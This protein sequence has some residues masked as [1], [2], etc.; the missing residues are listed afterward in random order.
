TFQTAMDHQSVEQALQIVPA[1]QVTYQWKGNTL[2]VQPVAGQLAPNTQYRLTLGSTAT[3]SAGTQLGKPATIVFVT[4]P[5]PAPALPTPTPTPVATGVALGRLVD[6]TPAVTVTP[7][8]SPDSATLYYAD[9]NRAL[10]S[11]PAGGGAPV[12]LGVEGVRSIAVKADG[13]SLAVQSDGGLID[14]LK[15]DGGALHTYV[16]PDA[17]ALGWHQDQLLAVTPTAVIDVKQQNSRVH[18]LASLSAVARQAVFSPDGGKLLYLDT[19]GTVHEV[20]LSSGHDTAWQTS[21]TGLPAWS[22]DGEHAAF[23]SSAQGLESAG[24][25]GSAPAQLAALAQLGLTSTADVSLAWSGTSVLAGAPNVLSGV[26]LNLRRPAELQQAGAAALS[27]APDGRSVAFVQN[28]S[29]WTGVVARPGLEAQLEQ[30]AATTI[31]AFM[32]A[33]KD[34]DAAGAGKYLDPAGQQAYAK[35]TLI[36]NG[37]PKLDRWFSVFLQAH[38][39]GRVTAMLRLVL[40]DAH[41]LEV[42]QLDEILTLVPAPGGTSLV[43]GVQQTPARPV[44][45][46]PEVL[47]VS[48]AQG[49][50]QITF[51]SD[52]KA[53]SINGM[54]L[55]NAAG[56][57]VGESPAYSSRTVTL[58]FGSAKP[59]DLLTLT[60]PGAVHDVGGRAVAQAIT[61]DIVVPEPESPATSPSPSPS[62]SASP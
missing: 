52:L 55:L 26:D 60:I 22:A 7:A 41:G 20:D 62:P 39:D 28:G 30:Q 11:V 9:Q 46:G 58:G 13:T 14:E 25:D 34:G 3:T 45:G 21:A 61:I 37:T 5:Q 6:V 29:L 51:D 16:V 19:A 59:G 44:D 36:F 47:S 49:Q 50:V 43:D 32:T 24:P 4:S 15:S 38:P 2:L 33:R 35:G 10:Q 31:A 53:D 56:V 54:A 48:I 23:L 8:W 57:A 17:L 27:G 1:T 18:P 40:Q 42:Q 12:S